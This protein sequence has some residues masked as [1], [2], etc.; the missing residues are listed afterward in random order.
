MRRDGAFSLP[1]A[2]WCKVIPTADAGDLLVPRRGVRHSRTPAPNV[3]RSFMATPRRRAG[4][5]A[6]ADLQD[7]RARGESVRRRV[8][9]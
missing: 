8:T 6:G 2:G 4:L 1:P 7:A 3:S 9:H 5:A